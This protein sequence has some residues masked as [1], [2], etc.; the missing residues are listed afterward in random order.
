MLKKDY[1]SMLNGNVGCDDVFVFIWLTVGINDTS[2]RAEYCNFGFNKSG[3]FCW[4]SD[5][6]WQD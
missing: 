2:V 1:A 5:E 4:P 6:Y 3:R